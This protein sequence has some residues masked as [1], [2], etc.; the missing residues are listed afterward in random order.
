ML[1]SFCTFVFFCAVGSI[2]VAQNPQVTFYGGGNP[3]VTRVPGAK[4][5]G[6]DG[7]L[8]LDTH[9]LAYFRF[10][11]FLTL[12]MPVGTYHFFA[13]TK[14]DKPDGSP[15]LELQMVAGQHYFVRVSESN[16]V[17]DVVSPV[18]L[19]QGRIELVSCLVA[20]K[21]AGKMRPLDAK[22]LSDDVLS[23]AVDGWKLPTCP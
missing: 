5:A 8:F 23:Q 12:S 7:A 6:L 4:N 1:R 16:G 15:M 17:A 14:Y 20:Q 11:R 19:D 21:E 2:A 9:R 18:R 22:Y 10:N 13:S 3:W